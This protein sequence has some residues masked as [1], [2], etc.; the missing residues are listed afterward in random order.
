MH[1]NFTIHL[2]TKYCAALIMDS[3]Y[4]PLTKAQKN[5]ESNKMAETISHASHIHKNLHF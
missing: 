2:V 1:C 3:M 4:N 5:K